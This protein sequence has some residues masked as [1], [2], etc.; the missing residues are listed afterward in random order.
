MRRSIRPARP[1]LL[2]VSA[3]TAA[4]TCGLVPGAYAATAAAPRVWSVPADEEDPCPGGEPKPCGAAPGERDSVEAGR[5]D[6]A[7][8]TETANQ[9]IKEAKKQIEECRP[10]SKECMS[11]LTGSGAEERK[12][13]DETRQGLDAFKPAPADN[14]EKAVDGACAAFAAELPAVLTPADGSGKLTSVCELMNP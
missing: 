13:M 3:V 11:G 14:A 8:A 1:L 10:S 9:D 12:G 4:V 6:A 7:K 5:K 2:L